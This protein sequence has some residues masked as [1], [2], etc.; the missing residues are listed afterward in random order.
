M[1][2]P[3]E[4]IKKKIPWDEIVSVSK[5]HGLEPE[6]LGAIVLTE[7]SGDQWA[8]RFE[9]HYKWLFQVRENAVKNRI[10]EDTE[11]VL[12]MCSFG[13]CQVMGAVARELGMKGPIF[14]LL[15]INSN[16][17]YASRLINRLRAKYKTNED[18]LAAYNAGSVVK[19]Q[20][21]EYRNQVY[22]NKSMSWYR[23]LKQK[24]ETKDGKGT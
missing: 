20:N 8:V 9:P 19:L 12:Q 15:S 24:V 17:T 5:Q 16:L 13:L 10:T 22:V 21:G 1:L 14:E 2:A 11:K 4:E 7:S 18:V 3:V 23:H 6:F